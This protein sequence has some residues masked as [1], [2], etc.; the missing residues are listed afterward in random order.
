MYVFFIF[1]FFFIYY[2]FFYLPI[3]CIVGMQADAN[4]AEFLCMY[5]FF[6]LF[7]FYFFFFYYYFYIPI[8]CIVGMQADANDA[9]FLCMYF[10]YYYY[11]YFFFYLYI[12]FYYYFHV[13]IKC[14]VG[15]QADANDAEFLCFFFFFFFLIISM[16]LSNVLLGC[17][18]MQ[19]MQKL[20]VMRKKK[21]EYLEYQ[22]QLAVHR[23]AQAERQLMQ[24][25]YYG[26][27]APLMDQHMAPQ[28]MPGEKCLKKITHWHTFQHICPSEMNGA[29]LIL[30]NFLVKR[31][32]YSIIFF[33]TI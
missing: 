8:K 28:P 6:L 24:G 12:F 25:P 17:R 29:R 18:Q 22:R 10:F 11:Y 15:M 14:I 21:Q 31:F 4:D 19:M 32:F 2:I 5:F 1:L 30:P 9:E 33:L 7:F 13:P 16:C 20:E 27:P 3:K 23:M 26:G